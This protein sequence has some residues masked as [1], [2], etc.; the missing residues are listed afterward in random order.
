M[1]KQIRFAAMAVVIV[2][3]IGLASFKPITDANP[4]KLRELQL[5]EVNYQPV[6]PFV[7]EGI[8]W[9]ADAQFENGGWGAG[10]HRAQQVRDP[11][12]VKTDPGTTAFAGMA[13]L[14]SGNTLTSG[15][16]NLHVK[17]ALEFLL[18]TVEEF[19]EEGI[20]ITNIT[21]TQPQVKMGANIDVSLTSQFFTKILIHTA[22]DPELEKRVTAAL[23]KCI[24]KIERSQNNDGSMAGGSWAGVL[25]SAMA[26]EALELA[27]NIGRPVDQT[28]IQKSKNYQAGNI[29]AD[30]TAVVGRSAG[31]DLYARSSNQRSI[32]KKSRKAQEIFE[33]AKKSGELD[34]DAELNEATFESLGVDKEEAKRLSSAYSTSQSNKARFSDEA[35][36]S[37]FGNNGGEEFL[38]YMMTSESMVIEGGDAWVEWN[39][40]MT[41]RLSKIQNSDGSWSGHHCITSPVFCTAAV[42]LTLT[43]ENDEN[44]LTMDSGD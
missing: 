37:G 28:V 38:S 33:E 44:I 29:S 9:L 6:E 40:K 35:V 14:R 30:G 19:P 39:E 27:D 3:I 15:Q 4:E 11:R 25:Q 31:V 21:G 22:F 12:A 18:K 1:K 24:R 8:D 43:A 16:Y 2:S 10:S 13:L 20:K 17:K 34:E 5:K 26:D 36:M 41:V 7:Q 42:I 32:A 23:D